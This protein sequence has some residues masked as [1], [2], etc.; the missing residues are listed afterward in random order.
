MQTALQY[1]LE[2]LA[3]LR[4]IMLRQLVIY[5]TAL[6]ILT[7]V[8]PLLLAAPV[9]VPPFTPLAVLSWMAN[10]ASIFFLAGLGNACLAFTNAHATFKDA[11]QTARE[12]KQKALAS[13][14]L[15]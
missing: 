10:H 6:V 12:N 4:R 7:V 11:M 3:R 14:P 13:R 15:I 2:D 1:R 5:I 8:Q 9:A